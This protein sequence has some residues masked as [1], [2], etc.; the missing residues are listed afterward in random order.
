MWYRNT[1]TRTADKRE[2]LKISQAVGVGFLVMGA[3]VRW[4][5]VEAILDA[6]QS[7][8]RYARKQAQ[9]WHQSLGIPCKAHS[10]SSQ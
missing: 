9:F 2:F 3:V 4:A 1:D 5:P 10:H 6:L 7:A 8:H